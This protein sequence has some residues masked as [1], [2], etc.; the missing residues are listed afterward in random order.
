MNGA[1]TALPP[2]VDGAVNVVRPWRGVKSGR[3]GPMRARMFDPAKEP[4][5]RAFGSVLAADV[6]GADGHTALRKGTRLGAIHSSAL[7][8][9]AGH[10]LHLIDLDPGELEQDE[11]ARRLAVIVAGPGTRADV[12]AQGQARVRAATRGLLHTRADAIAA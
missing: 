12:P 7:L 9:L 3:L 6:T 8:V 5:D 4:L 10:T 11:V 1:S 2:Y